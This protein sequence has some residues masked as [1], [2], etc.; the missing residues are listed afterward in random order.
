MLKL[1]LHSSF[2]QHTLWQ[3][4]PSIDS[5]LLITLARR[6]T[7][8]CACTIN[9]WNIYE[10][11]ISFSVYYHLLLRLLS[12]GT[13]SKSTALAIFLALSAS[14]VGHGLLMYT[15]DCRQTRCMKWNA[16][17][18]WSRHAQHVF[19][20][21]LISAHQARIDWFARSEHQT[22][23]HHHRPLRPK[24]LPPTK[25]HP[26]MTSVVRTAKNS[27]A[28]I[29]TNAEVVCENGRCCCGSCFGYTTLWLVVEVSDNNDL[30]VKLTYVSVIIL[31][32]KFCSWHTPRQ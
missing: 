21:A 13:S 14:L 3:H 8:V 20:D 17:A 1:F 19:H 25:K 11:L 2:F 28:A 4:E 6:M 5:F 15:S 29:A 24:K 26:P 23:W 32:Q 12:Y 27:S 9:K 16:L 7:T 10:V 30:V 31:I 18:L 22:H